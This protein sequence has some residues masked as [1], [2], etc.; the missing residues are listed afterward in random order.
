MLIKAGEKGQALILIALAAIGLF[1]FAA[2]AIDGSI[3]FSDKRHAQNAA[4]TAALAGSLAYI[5]GNDIDAAAQGRATDNGYDDGALSDI[6]ITTTDIAAGSGICPGD[7]AGKEIKV[8]ITS[9][10][11]TTFARVIGWS[12]VTNFVTATARGCDFYRAPLFNGNA[13]VGLKPNTGG[14][15]SFDSGTSDSAHWKVEGSGIFSNGC[16]YSKSDEPGDVSVEL[17]PGSCITSVGTASNF[18]CMNANQTSQAIRYP[19]DVLAIMPPNPCDGTPGDVGLPPPANGSTFSNGVYCISDL[20]SYDQEDIVLNNA[21]LYVTDTTFDLKF[22]GG[23]G[24]YGTPSQGG[25]FKNY[26]M[27]VPYLGTPCPSFTSNNT[28]VIE[29]RGNGGGT[30]YGT[31]LAPSACLDIRGNGHPSGMHTQIIGYIV[32][33]NGTAEVY[34]NYNEDENHKIPVNPSLTL[35]K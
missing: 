19:D 11:D 35:V 20:D 5:R 8:D 32:G 9:Y 6:T 30:F 7:V 3:V 25:D 2:L 23:G 14:D 34:I 27:V 29:W 22:A 33:S 24:F 17:D 31:V 28:Q 15:C 21:T 18:T 1:G 10:V 4:D 16:A 26:Y 12:K 13:I